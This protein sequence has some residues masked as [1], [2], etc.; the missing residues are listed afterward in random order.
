MFRFH[1][2]SQSQLGVKFPKVLLPPGEAI[3]LSLLVGPA[4][5]VESPWLHRRGSCC[6]RQFSAICSLT[7]EVTSR[8]D[9]FHSDFSIFSNPLTGFRDG[10][11]RIS[12]PVAAWM[13]GA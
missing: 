8:V 7:F 6:K 3:D 9:L 5:G 1:M 12:L 11:L 10:A 2:I 4:P 13:S